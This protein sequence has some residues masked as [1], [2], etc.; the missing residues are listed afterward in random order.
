MFSPSK[1]NYFADKRHIL[2]AWAPLLK[3]SE[4]SLQL[5]RELYVSI[6]RA[7][8]RVVVLVKKDQAMKAF[9]DSLDC[10]LEKS[11]ANAVMLEFN[12]ETADREW[13]DEGQSNFKVER[14]DLA[15][16]RSR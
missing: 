10:G 9:F 12:V 16:V 5:L 2:I 3:Q 8:R 13:F 11:D 1:A 14:Y 4:D 6:T 7:K 15:E